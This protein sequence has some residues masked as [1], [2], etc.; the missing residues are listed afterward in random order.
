MSKPRIITV[1][2]YNQARSITSAAVLRRF[3][4]GHE[5]LS[6]GIQANPLQPIPSTILEIL[7][8]WDLAEFDGRSTKVVDLPTLTETDL[9]LCA[10]AEVKSKLIEQLSI[11]NANAYKIRILEEYSRSLLEIPVDPVSMDEADTKT[12]L[13]RAIILSMRAARQEFGKAQPITYSL[14]P[15]DRAEHL[16]AQ[17]KLLTLITNNQGLIVDSG[18]SIPN[19]LLWRATNTS[20]IPINPNRLEID[21]IT[22][23]HSGILI[24][25]FEIDRSAKIFL[26]ENY[27]DFLQGLVAEQKIY[28]LAQPYSELPRARHHEAILSLIHS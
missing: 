13:A 27:C 6:A 15:Q 17:Q 18:F 3:F 4:P 5:V 1:C 2:K 25:K 9:V 14:F 21:S 26:S 23:N 19:P 11:I 16:Q 22:R 24:S 20:F 7:D 10:D 12:Q 8:E 28:L